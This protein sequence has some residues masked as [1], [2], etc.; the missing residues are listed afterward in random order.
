MTNT[1]LAILGRGIQ[2]PSATSQEWVLT[3]DLEICDKKGAHLAVRVPE[4]DNVRNSVI[5]GGE[6][7]VLAGALLARKLRPQ[8]V[9]CAY[10]ARSKY[11]NSIGA[12]SE[13]QIMTDAFL[14]EAKRQNGMVPEVNIFNEEEWKADASGTNRELYNVFSLATRLRVPKVAILTV[15]V[16][17]PRTIVMA[18]EHLK[19]ESKFKGITL[20]CHAS[21]LVLLDADPAKYGDRVRRIFGSKSYAR[22]LDRE[23][24]GINDLFA[25]KYKSIASVIK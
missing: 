5:G 19:K 2:H 9:T 1:L 15:A 25:G 10:G 4:N 21:E 17:L 24:S 12:P 14:A 23:M 16:H 3:P 22:N 8:I 6:L 18:Q 7:N 11:L 13:S 20:E